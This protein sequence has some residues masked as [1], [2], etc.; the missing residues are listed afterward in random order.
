[1]VQLLD[2]QRVVHDGFH[3]AFT[4]LL[5][6]KGHYYLAFRKAQEHGVAPPGEVVI[7]RSAD[8]T[9]W[10]D[11]ARISTGG[12][13]RDPKLID[14]GDHLA[15][16][17]GTWFPRW[18]D[19]SLKGEVT[20]DLVSHVCVSRDG[21]IWSAPRQVYGVNYWLWRVFA[22]ADEG[23][24]C[25]AYHFPRRSS[26]TERSIHLLHSDDL[27][28]WHLVGLM[29]E[30]DGPGEPVLYQPG[31]GVLHCVIRREAPDHRTWLGR[32]RAPYT[33]W[34]WNDMGVMIHAPVVI[35][36]EGKWLVAGR[37]RPQDLPKG[38]VPADS[39]AHTSLWRIT[40]EG[41]AEHLLTVPSGGD[42]SYC[43]F[44]QDPEGQLLMSY[45]SQHERL[46]LPAFPPTPADIFLARIRL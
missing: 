40:E 41:L 32:A 16:V 18:A 42:C 27:F 8:L 1:M 7:L 36:I 17:F 37:S 5:R 21:L 34:E 11:C 15:I 33:E 6:W 38:T 29:R 25:S 12:D 26:R 46:P 28:D 22:S 31:P 2:L 35:E 30:G 23:F 19:G 3:N 45:Y 10:E 4:D 13:D 9:A 39:G 43:G 14:A 24:F 44:A 20:H